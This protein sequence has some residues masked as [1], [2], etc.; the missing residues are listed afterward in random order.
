[1]CTSTKALSIKQRKFA[2]EQKLY[3]CTSYSVYLPVYHQQAAKVIINKSKNES[4][5]NSRHCQFYH[6]DE[7]LWTF[8]IHSL[9][10]TATSF[11]AIPAL[12]SVIAPLRAIF[13]APFESPFTGR[14]SSRF[15]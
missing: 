4:Y 7:N 3:M 9:F 2:L 12:C 10:P 8:C 14:P 6:S 5:F 13:L 15:R 1:M 11:P